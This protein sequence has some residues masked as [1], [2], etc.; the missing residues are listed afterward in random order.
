MAE[1]CSRLRLWRPAD[2]VRQRW[3]Q[4]REIVAM[5]GCNPQQRHAMAPMTS[6]ER[7]RL[8]RQRRAQG[9]DSINCKACGAR[10][11]PH[12]ASL[13]RIKAGLCSSCWLKTPEGLEERR[14]RDR[15]RNASEARK[16]ATAERVRR[17]RAK[18]RAEQES[19]DG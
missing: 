12:M 3:R 16:V 15:R 9:E 5:L 18:K 17:Y 4:R 7:M 1:H 13:A 6:A 19:T 2:A 10:W 11:Q 14:E 8:L